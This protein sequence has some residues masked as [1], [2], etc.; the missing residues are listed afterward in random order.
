MPKLGTGEITWETDQSRF[1]KESDISNIV[2]I[3]GGLDDIV[4]VFADGITNEMGKGLSLE[5]LNIG[6][7]APLNE[8]SLE[9]S[10]RIKSTIDDIED[11]KLIA[12]GEGNKHRQGEASEYYK[13]AKDEY[14]AKL[15]TVNAAVRTYNSNNTYLVGN[16]WSET[17]PVDSIKNS[18]PRVDVSC[19][20][21]SKVT[22]T[23]SPPI[24]ASW[25]D[26]SPSVHN[27][28]YN[29]LV[30]AVKEANDFYDEHVVPAKQLKIECDT[31]DTSTGST[32]ATTGGTSYSP[33]TITEVSKNPDD[34]SIVTVKKGTDGNIQY[35]SK[36][37][38]YGNITEMIWYDS[39]GK[40][41]EKYEFDIKEVVGLTG[42]V[43]AIPTHYTLNDK[44]KLAQDE[45]YKTEEN[46]MYYWYDKDGN[47]QGSK[48]PPRERTLIT[49]NDGSIVHDTG[50]DK[51]ETL[52][53]GND[54]SIVHSAKT[55]ELT[56][57]QKPESTPKSGGSSSL[58]DNGES[59]IYVTETEPRTLE[60]QNII[61]GDGEDNPIDITKV[62]MEPNFVVPKDFEEMKTAMENT[63]PIIVIPKGKKLIYDSK[64]PGEYIIE[65]TENDVTLKYD[66]NNGQYYKL[67]ANG[68]PEDR[69]KPIDPET[70][71][72]GDNLGITG[73][74]G[75][76]SSYG[77]PIQDDL[78]DIYNDSLGG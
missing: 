74:F 75:N 53:T 18:Y 61:Y 4:D 29:Q 6:G 71:S 37:D 13:S 28:Y 63:E 52:I 22:Y 35:Q 14:S 30:N 62:N 25:D 9:L 24:I 31:L 64:G 15:I 27:G 42:V 39:E 49:G 46:T 66:Y 68:W 19:S 72:K 67:A 36:A 26:L 59:T 10:D 32:T 47:R 5:A 77:D 23:T 20:F 16:I 56:G 33:G 65:A 43:M 3:I 57:L 78:M 55:S 58:T 51:F 7:R 60:S 54:G 8:L 1:L 40:E 21:D 34:G 11:I 73:S 50:Y 38:R 69:N 45:N 44:G 76:D 41:K 48:E 12:Q 70:F 17:G 2:R